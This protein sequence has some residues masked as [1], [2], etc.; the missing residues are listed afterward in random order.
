MAHVM[1]G[2]GPI[3]NT[4]ESPA[5]TKALLGGAGS[6]LWKQL[7]NGM[8]LTGN[9][10]CIEYLVVPAGASIGEHTHLRTEEIYY[11]LS[12]AATMT[13][14]GEQVAVSAGDLIMNPINGRH[15]IANDTGEDMEFLVVEVFPGENSSGY[16]PERVPVRAKLTPGTPVDGTAPAGAFATLDLSGYFSGDWAEFF[17]ARIEP[18]G[19]LGPFTRDDRDQVLFVVE[20]QAEIAF[21]D[22]SV[23]GSA[24]L[25]A[26][27]PAGVTRTVRNK[28]TGGAL[29]VLS[30]EVFVR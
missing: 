16:L 23:S 15:G 30:T 1:T 11:I 25:T 29:E 3:T 20:G 14:N 21:G 10:N 9:W 12:G 27:V 8:H 6:C 13:V 18:S 2:F 26:A 7:I 24:G 4:Y 19:Q 17:V 28:S 22:E 5:R